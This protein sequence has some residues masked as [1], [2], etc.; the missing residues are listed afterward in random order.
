MFASDS[1]TYL[2][3][4]CGPL[5]IFGSRALS[6]LPI[7]L[8]KKSR[9]SRRPSIFVL[10]GHQRLSR[11]GRTVE[12]NA[13]TMF[14]AQLINDFRRKDT[15]CKGTTEDRVELRVQTADAHRFEIEVRV[16]NR[17]ELRF[18]ARARVKK[19]ISTNEKIDGFLSL[20]FGFSG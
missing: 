2:S 3:R 19:Q 20:P 13:S 16:N 15:R 14:H 9:S 5:T 11:S 8:K 10:P 6:I 17:N 12:E 1:P 18:S 4:I 7:C